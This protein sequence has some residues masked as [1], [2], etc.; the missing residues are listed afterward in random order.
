M[1]ITIYGIHASEAVIKKRPQDIYA[2][3]TLQ[4]TTNPR[5]QKILSLAESLGIQTHYETAKRLNHLTNTNT[6]QNEKTVHQGIIIIAKPNQPLTET[7]LQKHC[8]KIIEN[9]Q[10]PKQPQ[11]WIILDGIQDP[12][13]FG[14]ILRNAESCDCDGV[15][16]LNHHSAPLNQT[17]RKIASGAAELINIYQVS[18]IARAISHLQQVGIWC[19]ALDSP[20]EQNTEQ[21]TEQPTPPTPPTT[22]NLFTLDLRS[23][24]AFV[25]GAEGSGLRAKTLKYCDQTAYLPMMGQ[26]Q[27]LNV[28]HATTVALFESIRQRTQE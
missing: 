15:I 23:H 11:L 24:T 18:N 19:I 13:N 6:Q 26:T 9:P 3:H 21:N 5:L 16:M 4:N 20:E 27:S 25:M 28:S 2:L 12:Q 17:V 10:Q 22:H 8:Q 14:A 7:Q 1:Q